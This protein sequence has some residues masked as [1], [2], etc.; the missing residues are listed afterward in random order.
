MRINLNLESQSILGGAGSQENGLRTK[1][2]DLCTKAA[3][4]PVFIVCQG[5]TLKPVFIEYFRQDRQEA[6]KVVAE[7]D[8]KYSGIFW[9]IFRPV[10][11]P[12]ERYELVLKYR[13]AKE[14]LQE[15]L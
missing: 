7:Q 5:E 13:C 4:D 12:F 15:K 8:G 14:V 2:I 11:E 1:Y 3:T 9:R 6:E 10:V